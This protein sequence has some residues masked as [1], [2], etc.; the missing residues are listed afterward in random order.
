[1]GSAV[2]FLGSYEFMCV[3]RCSLAFL[4]LMG[5]YGFLWVLKF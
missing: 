3:L 1:M 4:V 5:C 2:F